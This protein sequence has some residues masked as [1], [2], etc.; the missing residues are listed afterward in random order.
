MVA[1]HLSLSA[2]LIVKV[3]FPQFSLFHFPRNYSAA[4]GLSLLSSNSNHLHKNHLVW[5]I[6]FAIS[7]L[8]LES[9]VY[10]RRVLGCFST[11]L[12][13]SRGL[14]KLYGEHAWPWGYAPAPA[15]PR[16]ATRLSFCVRADG[17]KMIAVRL[18]S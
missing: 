1:F 3:S 4:N 6:P 11:L 12:G 17:A 18:S 16:F 5:R 9:N 13:R 15:F 2:S 14:M 7:E 10:C 8:N